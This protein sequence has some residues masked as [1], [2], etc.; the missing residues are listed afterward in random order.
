MM[1]VPL[2]VWTTIGDVAPSVISGDGDVGQVFA[3]IGDV[4]TELVNDDSSLIGQVFTTIGD[5]L[6]GEL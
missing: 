3:S 1:A 4:S 2:T 6:P 5:L